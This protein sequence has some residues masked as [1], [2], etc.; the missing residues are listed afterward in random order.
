M[1]Q[2]FTPDPVVDMAV[3]IAAPQ[4]S[5][6]VLDP[7]CGSGHFLTRSLDY[8]LANNANARPDALHEF[9]FFHLHGIEKSERMARI[10]MTDM[11]LHDD[12]H[13]NIRN[14]D[15]LLRRRPACSWEPPATSGAA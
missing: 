11:L 4:L 14:T 3:K 13:T 2:Y 1:G 12:G 15:A 7:F 6:L 9:M 10:A 8:V 5:D